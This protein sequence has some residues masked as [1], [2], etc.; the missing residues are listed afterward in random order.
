MKTLLDSTRGVTMVI[1]ANRDRFVMPMV[2]L[3]A[4]LLAGHWLGYATEF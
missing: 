2:I 3:A 1:E 4:L